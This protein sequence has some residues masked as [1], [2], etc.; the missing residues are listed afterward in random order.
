M[1]RKV[2]LVVVGI[3][4][5][6]TSMFIGPQI[7]GSESKAPQKDKVIEASA[8]I[9]GIEESSG[10]TALEGMQAKKVAE[11]LADARRAEEAKEWPQSPRRRP[12]EEVD[13]D[14]I[15]QCETD[16]NWSMQGPRYSG[17]VGFY[18]G[19]WDSYGGREFASNAGL[20]TKE[21]QIIVASRVYA[22][23][24]LSGWGC[25]EYG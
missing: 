22:D 16:S 2:W 18:N 10:F 11:E 23:H 6:S 15:A 5:F 19:T 7:A 3:S 4:V 13:W 25:K 8:S 14:G 20:A 17:G 9:K 12:V 21:Q 24:G 1:K